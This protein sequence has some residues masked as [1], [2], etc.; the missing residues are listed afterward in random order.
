MQRL[1]DKVA[2]VNGGA[3]GIGGSISQRLA[4]EGARVMIADI[5]V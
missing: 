3:H 1:E 5:D 4:E 2:I